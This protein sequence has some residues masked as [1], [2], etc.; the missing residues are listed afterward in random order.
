MKISTSIVIFNNDFQ[1]LKDLIF[2]LSNNNYISKIFLINNSN[3]DLYSEL[4]LISNK[5]IYLKNNYN[6]GFGKGHNL[7]LNSLEKED[8]YHLVLNPDIKFLDHKIFDLI[9]K[10]M[11]DNLNVGLLVPK[12][13]YPDYTVYQ[14]TKLLPNP[15]NLI[16][17]RFI[18]NFLHD[19]FRDKYLLDIHKKDTIFNIPNLSGS[20]LFLRVETLKRV[21]LFDERF[22]LYLEDV[23]LVRRFHRISQTIYFPDISVIHLHAKASY[24]L[25][26]TFLYHVLS[27]I[28]YFNKWGWF[29]DKER[30]SFNKAILKKLD[31]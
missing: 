1:D 20:F 18:P 25:N 3:T 7:A 4:T 11:N 16:K 22:F 21:G 28:K 27:A 15:L 13:L 10:F 31:L 24:K 2:F 29:I 12:L 9:L 23:D 19:F 5:V 14:Q 26:R 30:D 8:I 17:A 6:L